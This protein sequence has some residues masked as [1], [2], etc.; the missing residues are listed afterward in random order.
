MKR[1]PILFCVALLMALGFSNPATAKDPQSRYAE[2]NG[3]RLHYLEAGKGSPVV[4]LHGYAETSHMW[5]PLISEL[6]KTHTVIAPDLRGSGQSS[7]PDGGYTK[8]EMAQDI[9]IRLDH[10]LRKDYI[11]GFSSLK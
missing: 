7:T 2:V 1:L 10:T 9:I 3:V 8:A 6:E 4:L 5:L 11:G